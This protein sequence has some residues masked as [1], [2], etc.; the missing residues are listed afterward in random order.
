MTELL[1]V[2][3]KTKTLRSNPLLRFAVPIL[4]MVAALLV[5]RVMWASVSD[6]KFIFFFG[7]IVLSAWWGGLLPGLLA[8]IL[9]V[10]ASDYLLPNSIGLTGSPTEVLQLAMFVLLS[11]FISWIENQRINS[12]KQLLAS[13]ARLQAIIANLSD[14]VT[15]QDAVGNVL[16]ANDAA[17]KLAGWASPSEM[18]N[19]EIGVMQRSRRLLNLDNDTVFP[20]EELPRMRAFRDGVADTARFRIQFVDTNEEHWIEVKSAPIRGVDG[21]VELAVSIFRDIEQDKLYENAL[22]QERAYLRKVLNNVVAFVGVLDTNGILIE[23]NSPALEVIGLPTDQ[24]IGKPLPD[25]APWSYSPERQTQLRD[26]I[27]RVKKGETVRYDDQVRIAADQLMIIDFMIAPLFDDKGNLEMMI[28]SAFDI[29]DRRRKEEQLAHM[30]MLLDA[31]RQRLSR[32]MNAIPAIVFEWTNTPHDRQQGFDFVN[33]YAEKMLGY[34]IQNWRD[35]P[36]F[37]E[38]VIEPD[39]FARVI[40]EATTIFAEQERGSLQFRYI[41]ADKHTVYAEAHT[42]IIRDASGQPVGACGVIMDITPRKQA[43]LSLAQKAEEL[44]RSNEELEQFAY[45]ASHDLQEP[46]RM[47]TSYLQLLEKRYGERLDG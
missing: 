25:T 7:G 44:Q 24:L 3:P 26:A 23:A 16:V 22:R 17:A 42:N 19:Q 34:P 1:K 43:E 13:N 30:T 31:Q 39:D 20:Y 11:I 28:A 36:R 21:H 27:A 40:E 9:A 2:L 35:D 47:V 45:V 5:T 46:L 32:I 38:K 41:A 29:T 14:G 4:L 10:L 12:E 8:T 18:L 37:G 6:S 15:V 33:D